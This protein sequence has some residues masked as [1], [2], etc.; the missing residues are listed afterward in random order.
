MTA[1]TDRLANPVSSVIKLR[2]EDFEN[3]AY[4]VHFANTTTKTQLEPKAG[5]EIVEFAEKKVTLRVP[6][7]SCSLGHSL[8]LEIDILERAKDKDKIGGK[9][10]ASSKDVFF[11][12]TGKVIDLEHVGKKSTIITV[13]FIQY[14]ESEWQKFIA[15]FVRRQSRVNKIFK[16]IKE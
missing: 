15:S 6:R 11:K 5:V 2:A 13:E 12:A 7:L 4:T 10:R 3:L 8:L 1:N 14:T 16:M 9:G